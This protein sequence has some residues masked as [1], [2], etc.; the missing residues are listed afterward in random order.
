MEFTETLLLMMYPYLKKKNATPN[1]MVR[2][3]SIL[4][5]ILFLLVCKNYL[6]LFS[7]K[8]LAVIK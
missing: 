8:R 3:F 4:L 7:V 5:K 1:G 6:T 2:K